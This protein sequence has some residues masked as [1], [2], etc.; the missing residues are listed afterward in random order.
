MLSEKSEFGPGK[1]QAYD[2]TL[3]NNELDYLIEENSMLSI[4]NIA[5]E[6][7]SKG[8]IELMYGNEYGK[9]SR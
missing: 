9:S 2:L 8:V 7:K 5:V 4:D 3:L 6:T 1:I